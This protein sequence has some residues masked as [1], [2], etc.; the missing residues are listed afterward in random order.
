M[1]TEQ[2]RRQL[3]RDKRTDRVGD[4]MAEPSDASYGKYWLRPP[5]G[6]YEWDVPAEYIELLGDVPQPD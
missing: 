6:G 5:G 1:P 2:R 3:A 4:V